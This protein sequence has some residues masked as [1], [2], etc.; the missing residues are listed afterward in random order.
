[1][2]GRP[3]AGSPCAQCLPENG[4]SRGRWSMCGVESRREMPTAQ[5]GS[6]RWGICQKIAGSL[7]LSPHTPWPFLSTPRGGGHTYIFFD[8]HRAYGTDQGENPCLLPGKQGVSVPPGKSLTYIFTLRACLSGASG[9]DIK[10]SSEQPC[11]KPQALLRLNLPQ[12]KHQTSSLM[13]CA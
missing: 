3:D 9:L 4:V 12:T 13:L 7:L 5:G 11:S 2:G 1:M 10:L 6:P 8:H